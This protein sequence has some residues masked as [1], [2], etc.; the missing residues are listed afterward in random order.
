MKRWIFILTFSLLILTACSN[1]FHGVT[2]ISP[3]VGDPRDP[4]K[5][6]S[7]Q[8]TLQWKASSQAE[9][10]YDVI[11]YEGI[12]IGSTFDK[13]RGQL[14]RAVGKMIYYR[15]GIKETEHRVEEPLKPDYEYYWSV[16]IRQGDQTSEWSRYD[17]FFFA[18][19]GYVQGDNLT[20]SFK[21][22]DK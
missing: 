20:F 12:V 8:P 7:L 6:K 22:P 11:I 5:V 16:R 9:V 2:V 17:F 10:T 13:Y 3:K 4:T 14:K 18:G 21:T 19:V 15:E 1:T